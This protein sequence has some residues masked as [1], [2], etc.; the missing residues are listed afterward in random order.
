MLV[1]VYEEPLKWDPIAALS[2]NL[3]LVGCLGGNFPAAIELLKSGKAKTKDMITHIFPLD[4]AAQAF[5]AQ[6]ADQ[7]AIKVMIKP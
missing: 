1:G 3:T 7:K 6:L 2:K 5:E 4:E